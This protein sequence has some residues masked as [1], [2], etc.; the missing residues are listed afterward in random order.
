[1]NDIEQPAPAANPALDSARAELTKV[2]TDTT[3]PDHA[4]FRRGDEKVVARIGSLYT[5]AVGSAP[6]PIDDGIMITGKPDGQSDGQS[7]DDMLAAQ[8]IDTMLRHT[9]GESYDSEMT[10]MRIGARSLFGSENGPAL[11]DA[12][13]PIVT[14]LGPEAEVAG[15]RFLAHL[16][17]LTQRRT[18]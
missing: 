16:G 13:N 14:A 4:A 8:A 9:L 2:M 6:A 10:D 7:S 11:F 15:V 18:S 1:M 5:K 17:R 3:H 12:L